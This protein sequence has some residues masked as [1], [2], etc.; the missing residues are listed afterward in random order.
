MTSQ[1]ESN[2]SEDDVLDRAWDAFEAGEPTEALS[3]VAA[4]PETVGERALLEGRAYLELGM[5]RAASGA[6]ERA[7]AARGADDHDVRALDAEV[8][9]LT[10][11]L[12]GA[13][14]ILESLAREAFDVEW[15]DRRSLLAD[16]AGDRRG[17]DAILDEA[18]REAPDLVV[19]PARVRD[20]VFDSIV[21]QAIAELPEAFQR[22]IRMARIVREPMPWAQLAGPDPLAVP[23]DVMGLFV[24]PTLHELAEDQS[25]ALPPVI[26]LFK[27]NIE[28]AS[29]SRDD[30]RE[31]IRVTLFHE[32]GHLLGLDEDQVAE[33]GLA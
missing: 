1:R 8:R 11:D 18:R 26:Y 23:P 3:I 20:E 31:E 16:L 14:A 4:V 30:L 32:V 29:Q 12:D 25:G 15:W 2:E 17:A 22:A 19:K 7:A 13:R 33:M 27:R 28:R 6:V 5:A 21:E 9:L 24:G 10:W